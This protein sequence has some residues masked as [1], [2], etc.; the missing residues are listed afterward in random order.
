[1]RRANSGKVEFYKTMISIATDLIEEL[2]GSKLEAIDASIEPRLERA[3]EFSNI[4]EL[5]ELHLRLDEML[6][7][8][9]K[10][11]IFA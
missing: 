4:K 7:V 10:K 1:M 8:T 3:L 9:K 6:A 11:G 5:K 2:T